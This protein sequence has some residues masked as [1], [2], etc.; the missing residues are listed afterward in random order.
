[1]WQTPDEDAG[2]AAV[3]EAI[4]LGINF[5]DTAPFYGSGSAERVRHCPAL[6][7]AMHATLLPRMQ[8]PSTCA[9]CAL[10]LLGRALKDFPRDQYLICTKVGDTLQSTSHSY[11]HELLVGMLPCLCTRATS[12][13]LLACM[14]AVLQQDNADRQYCSR[15]W[16]KGT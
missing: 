15:A 1:M 3:K 6:S 4:E 8:P 10:Q 13:C 5:F 11:T 9:H 14:P 2:I 12:G 16:Q 7:V